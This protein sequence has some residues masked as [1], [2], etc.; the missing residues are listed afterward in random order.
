MNTE[1]MRSRRADGPRRRL[2]GVFLTAALLVAAELPATV[3]ASTYTISGTVT[4]TDGTTPIAGV[5][6]QACSPTP[7]NPCFQATTDL[8]GTYTIHVGAGSYQIQVGITDS[9][10]ASGFY[11]PGFPGNFTMDVSAQFGND[12]QVGTTSNPGNASLLDV[13]LP[14]GHW[15]SGTVADTSGNALTGIVVY[16]CEQSPL[17]LTD[18][19]RPQQGPGSATT[20]S[21]GNYSIWVADSASYV[22]EFSDPN[23]IYAPGL[24][25]A[26]STTPPGY[27]AGLSGASLVPVSGA[28]VT[29]INVELP[30]Y[31]QAFPFTISGS[32]ASAGDGATPLGTPLGGVQV[33]ACGPGGCYQASTQGGTDPY[34][35]TYTIHVGAG[36]YQI[37]VGITDSVF[38]S[39]FYVPGFPGNFT[40]DVSAQFGNDVQV[41]T[42]SNPGNASLLDVQLPLGHWLS[43]TVA[44]TSGNALTG[45]VVYA[46]EQS[47]LPLTD[48]SRPQQGPGS[49]T[50]DSTGNYSI[51]V[52]DSASYVV[53]FSDPNAIYAPGLY[54][55]SSTTPPGYVAGLSGASLVPVSG[56]AVTGINVELPTITASIGTNV[57][58]QP[59]S[60]PGASGPV[61]L[62]FA[63]VT[64]GGTVSVSTSSIAPPTTNGGILGLGNPPTYFDVSTT[65][66]YSGSI[67]IC[68]SYAGT[69][70]LDPTQLQ[71]YH[72]DNGT[73]V[74]ITTSLNTTTQVICGT[75]TSLSP[76]AVAQ[77]AWPFSGL[78]APVA[79]PP[80]TNVAKAGSTIPVKFSLGGYRGLAIFAPGYPAWVAGPCSSS[81]TLQTVTS[82]STTTSG[83]IYDATS[84][85][86]LYTWQT[87]P[88]WTG[89]CGQFVLWLGDNTIHVANFS[90]H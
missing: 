27:V 9:V 87:L 10:F 2:F 74:D 64:A 55:A 30:T 16:A 62:T 72:D 80:T 56:A 57:T 53:E 43:G 48:C 8:S 11:V 42:T 4:A 51:W 76:F 38:A 6:V 19:S 34:P 90:F 65:V 45:I 7:P 5:G 85:Q 29:G 86:Y 63:T 12:V 66:V 75:T 39:G 14:L 77:P 41:G 68:V 79:N 84:G 35:G 59:Q 46:C 23:A 73:W 40:M 88:A 18:C 3:V 26:S 31:L 33:Q 47:P 25:A 50:T 89:Q 58:V 15:L 82:T 60:S 37:Q 67:T 52:A 17:P 71:L 32:I 78:F 44:D 22:V 1:M 54:A 49:A 69:S 70:Y 83:L 28:A 81:G 20:D 61:T 36:S 13:Q 24:Y 21:T